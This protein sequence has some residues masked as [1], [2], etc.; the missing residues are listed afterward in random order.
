[1][2]WLCTW[3]KKSDLVKWK[4]RAPGREVKREMDGGRERGWIVLN[5]V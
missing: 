4:K 1:M 5:V 3:K 2:D